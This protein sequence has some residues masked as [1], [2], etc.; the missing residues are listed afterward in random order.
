MSP[1]KPMSLLIDEVISNE[2]EFWKESKEREA[3][4]LDLEDFKAWDA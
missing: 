2:I 4:Q 3:E 1:I